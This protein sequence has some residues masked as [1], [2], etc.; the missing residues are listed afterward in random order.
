MKITFTPVRD[1][2]LGKGAKLTEYLI[3]VNGL[4]LGM[5]IGQSPDHRFNH[6]YRHALAE[7]LRDDKFFVWLH[8]YDPVTGE[9][10][11]SVDADQE[12]KAYQARLA[13]ILR[14]T[15]KVRRS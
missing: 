7:S 6:P 10:S 8:A 9:F 14:T 11:A 3:T 5:W 13:H 1:R 2:P 4:I 12:D 15:G